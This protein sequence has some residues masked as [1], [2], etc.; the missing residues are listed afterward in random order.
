L[1]ELYREPL[2]FKAVVVDPATIVG[3]TEELAVP[4]TRWLAW[5]PLDLAAERSTSAG[6]RR[7]RVLARLDDSESTPLLVH[8]QLGQGQV[9][10]S[11]TSL[12]PTW[13]NLAQTNAVVSWDHLLRSLIR[14][15]LPKRNFMAQERLSVPLGARERG[16]TVRL[17]RPDKTRPTEVTEVGF[18]ESNRAGVT[19]TNAWQRGLYQFEAAP[20]HGDQTGLGN[21]EWSLAVAVQGEAS[22]SNLERL[23]EEDLH[24]TI[25][26]P[27]IGQLLSG[28]TLGAVETAARGS[29]LWWWFTLVVFLLLS[30]E[31]ALLAI[32]ARPL[33]TE[34]RGQPGV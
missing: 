9:L 28:D 8:H 18:I 33:S 30:V 26:E 11:T 12:L 22:E 23:A 31:L 13:N 32:S 14:S 2:F 29:A 1:G 10:F 4:S 15:T 17:Y 24:A 16:V 3:N 25:I 7:A 21:H 20:R 27:K 19:I 5:R 6:S 34:A